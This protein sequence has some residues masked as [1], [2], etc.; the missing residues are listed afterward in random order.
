MALYEHMFLVRQDATPAQVDA[1]VEQM[2]GVLESLGGK[3]HKVESWGLR[4]L[5]YRMKKNRKAHYAFMNIEGPW[6]ALAE[7]ERQLKLNED[8]LRSLTI[9]VEEHEEGP[10]AVL[11]RRERDERRGERD[12]FR[13]GDRGDF[14]GGDRGDFRG[15]DR[16]ERRPPRRRDD[17]GVASETPVEG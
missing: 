8:V 13:G 1:L 10:S 11:L 16:G 17:E 15:G 12:D 7:M 5:A 3:V 2:K 4:S 9:R 14:R 6:A